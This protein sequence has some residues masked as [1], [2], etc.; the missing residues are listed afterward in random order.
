[1][2]AKGGTI[3]TLSGTPRYYTFIVKGVIW[4]QCVTNLIDGGETHNSI[5]V[6][7]VARRCISIEDFE[8]FNVV[9]AN[10]FNMTCTHKIVRMV[11]TLGNYNLTNDF[12]VVD[13]V[14]KNIALGVQWIHSIGEITMN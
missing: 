3:T 14:D 2:E 10:G 4:G 7:L 6:A 9:V 12:Y 8:G 1:V 13:L 5:D 11:L